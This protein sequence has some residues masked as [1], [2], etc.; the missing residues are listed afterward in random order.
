MEYTIEI[1]RADKRT[2]AGKKLVEVLDVVGTEE[3]AA[4]IACDKITDEKM[5][6]VIHETYRTVRNLMSGTEVKLRYDA[7]CYCSVA[8]ESYWTA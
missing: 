5:T 1:Y 4:S 3:E 7:P 8:S 2:K 6:F